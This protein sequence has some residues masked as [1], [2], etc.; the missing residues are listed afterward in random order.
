MGDTNFDMTD[1]E[2]AAMADDTVSDDDEQDAEA[3]GDEQEQE[4]ATDEPVAD[5]PVADV[6]NEPEQ[7]A[8]DPEVRGLEPQHAP[9]AAS[10]RL[11][12]SRPAE[13]NSKLSWIKPGTSLIALKQKK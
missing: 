10:C 4:P 7:V 8:A 6:E 2:L 1:E 11:M 12:T 13:A 3:D 5:E 9:F